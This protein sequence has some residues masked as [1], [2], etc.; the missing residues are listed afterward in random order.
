MATENTYFCLLNLQCK[1]H[2]IKL[3]SIYYLAIK[4]DKIVQFYLDL[5]NHKATIVQK[6]VKFKI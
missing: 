6:K 3:W 2:P 5:K 1:H 4:S